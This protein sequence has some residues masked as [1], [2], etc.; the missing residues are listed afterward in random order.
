M[1]CRASQQTLLRLLTTAAV[2]SPY[3]IEPLT[4]EEAWAVYETLVSDDRIA[5]GAEPAGL[6]F[7]WKEFARR[8]TASPKLW[9]DA[10][11]AAFATAAGWTMV[12]TDSAFR[13]FSGLD[14]LLLG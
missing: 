13:Q 2:L 11:L 8:E 1:F 5:F 9:M 4:N 6:A 12:T 3:G 10:Y 14:L 7:R